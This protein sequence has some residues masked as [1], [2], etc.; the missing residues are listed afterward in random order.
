MGLRK[1]RDLSS[2]MDN[3]LSYSFE[4]LA[5]GITNKP[6][7][8]IIVTTILAFALVPGMIIGKREENGEKLWVPQDTKSQ[9]QKDWV[10][11]VYPEED[12]P[13]LAI[14]TSK[15]VNLLTRD[16]LVALQALHTGMMAVTASCE[17]GSCKGKTIKYTDVRAKQRYSVLSIWGDTV[18][19]VGT[20]ILADVNNK[21]KWKSSTGDTLKLSDMLG[22]VTYDSAG[23]I[24][25]AGAFKTTL[26]M[27]EKKERVSNKDEDPA[28][29]AWELKFD[30]YVNDFTHPHLAESY[31]QT[32]KGQGKAGG[33][34]IRKD[35]SMLAIG[36]LFLIVFSV[37][38]LSHNKRIHSNGCIALASVL[39]IGF[40]IVSTFGLCGYIG[41]KQN[42]VTNTLYLVLLGIGADDCY[43]IMGQ[44][45]REQGTPQERV[46][47]ALTKAG[48]SIAVTS[49]T[50]CLAFACGLLSTLPALR[51][52]CIFA[53]IGIMFDFLY[54]TTFLTAIIFFR[55]RSTENNRPD[56]LCCCTTVEPEATGCCICT[57]TNEKGEAEGLSRRALN[58]VTRF[59]L[60]TPGTITVLLVTAGLV[61]GGVAGLPKLK[62]DF[63]IKWF[64]P[65]GSEYK[66]MYDAMDKYFPTSGGY[67]VGIYTKSGDYAA[68][69]SDGS[70]TALYTRVSSCSAT[71]RGIGN[72][73]TDFTS[74][75]GRSTRAKA[76]NAAFTS[77]LK[78]FVGSTAGKRFAKDIVFITDSAGAAIGI[79]ASRVLYF[80]KETK[81]GGEDIKQV[82]AIRGCVGDTPLNA[83]AFAFPLL[84]ID[85]LEVVD[86]ETIQNVI[87][88]CACVF[89][90]TLVMLAD[91]LAA[92]M[93]LLMIA[94][95]D[96]CILGY[97]A[98]WGLDFNS[99]TAINLVLAVGLAVDYSAHIAHSFLVAKG[100]GM[101]R[102]TEAVDHIGSSVFNGAFSTF[103]AVLPLGLSKSYVFQVFFKMWFMIIIFGVYFGMIVLPVLLRFVSPLVGAEQDEA[104]SGKANQQKVKD[105]G[106]NGDA[107][108]MGAQSGA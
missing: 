13:A 36:Y 11:S 35:V 80:L 47:K 25:S 56:W 103:L 20:D 33:S 81:S 41:V 46:V 7:I 42:P 99:V 40:S 17:E 60:S 98:H 44:Y 105:D 64:I 70:L 93:V 78:T 69:H 89:L 12:R 50:D 79:I 65:D 3:G 38:V 62:A 53:A 52:F 95:V 45:T 59:T 18:P 21:A 106:T 14:S 91:L 1:V 107:V 83:L 55:A 101:E 96:V 28:T 104:A 9:D 90:V 68:A 15:G 39:S 54:Q 26:W 72:W 58:A 2:K 92:T 86:R 23:K 5:T 10:R 29:D 48:A 32:K 16:S 85:G 51:D 97:M 37:I 82:E 61:A 4:S 108:T 57:R 63:D 75:A 22:G 94:L 73:Y 77:E 88:A 43:V 102:A 76:S 71:D 100:S 84:F 31:A 30:D 74:D 66:E 67:P 87:I 34:A 19:P 49:M 27:K 8:T 6:I 24:I